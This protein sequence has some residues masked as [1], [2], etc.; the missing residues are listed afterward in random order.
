M[1]DQYYF[2]QYNTDIIYLEFKNKDNGAE[3]NLYLNDK[4]VDQKFYKISDGLKWSFELNH[5]NIVC[6]AGYS[7]IK[8][9]NSLKIDGKE[10]DL[11]KIKKKELKR[12]LSS[13]QIYNSVNP[14]K[15]EIENAKFKISEIYPFLAWTLVAL[16]VQYFV[17]DYD[18]YYQ[19][20]T[21]IPCFF[22]GVNLWGILI[23]YVPFLKDL[24]KL[25]LGMVAL[26]WILV[27]IIAETIF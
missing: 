9:N 3:L 26:N 20:V 5:E 14:S 22:G 7:G 15:E 13:K 18:K 8:A 1:F 25:V 23:K 21:L 2:K 4:Q 19:L 10:Y 6:N 11:P 17:N 16:V 24:R 27:K 12:L